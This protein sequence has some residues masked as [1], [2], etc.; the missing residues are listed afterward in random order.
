MCSHAFY[1]CTKNKS[2]SLRQKEKVFM[3]I[4]CLLIANA[5]GEENISTF[6]VILGGGEDK[7]KDLNALLAIKLFRKYLSAAVGY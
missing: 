3:K 5:N 2:I 7:S 1:D 6:F 4:R